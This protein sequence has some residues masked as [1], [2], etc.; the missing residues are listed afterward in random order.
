MTTKVIM[1]AGLLLLCV[2][3][4]K[5][6]K[7]PKGYKFTVVKKGDGVAGKVGQFLIIN[8]AFRDGKDSVWNDS[9]K[10]GAP[11]IINIQDTTAIKQEEGIEEIFRMLTKGDSVTCKIPAK[12]LFEK[13]IHA[14][15]PPNVDAKSDFSF[16][17]GV[18]DIMDREGVNKLQQE[19]VAKQNEKFKK[20]QSGQLAKDTVIID[21]FLKAKNTF[22]QKTA[23]GIRYIITQAGKGENAK[24]GQTVKVNYAGFLLN[25]KCFDTSIEAVAKANGVYNAGRGYAPYDLILGQGQV[26]SGWEEALSLMNKGS[27]MTVYIP[28]SLAYG[29]QRRSEDIVENSVLMFEM[30]LVDIKD[31]K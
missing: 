11:F 20:E 30:E 6:K 21:D 3:C 18:S 15:M 16:N 26:I 10:I 13:T 12:V 22:A 2:A 1:F 8:M 4:S 28:S 29:P 7:T 25:G 5:E 24:P 31:A 27:K 14:A 17:I 9:K 19:I 23:S